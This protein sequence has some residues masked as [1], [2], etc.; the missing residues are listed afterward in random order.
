MGSLCSLSLTVLEATSQQ[1]SLTSGSIWKWNGVRKW[2]N[3]MSENFETYNFIVQTNISNKLVFEIKVLRI[4]CKISNIRLLCLI[5]W[6]H[7]KSEISQIFS[8]YQ[9]TPPIETCIMYIFL[10]LFKR[11]LRLHIVKFLNLKVVWYLTYLIYLFFS[12]QYSFRN[13][14]SHFFHFG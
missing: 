3:L 10:Y 7:F 8:K 2:M 11:V 4:I 5:G 14:A 12:S 1:L 9:S 6:I 13:I